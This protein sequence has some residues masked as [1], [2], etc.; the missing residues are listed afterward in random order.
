MKR[1]PMNRLTA[2]ALLLLMALGVNARAATG[3][4]NL[5]N[6]YFSLGGDNGMVTSLQ[7]DA[8]GAGSYGANTIA[9]GGHLAFVLGGTLMT[10]PSASWSLAG[11]SLLISGLPDST[12]LLI[13]LVGA[14]MT[15]QAQFSGAITVQHEWDLL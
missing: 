15:V 7:L 10:A 8:T 13:S 11:S 5:S 6:G 3:P 1:I 12:S 14:K 9:S 2:T 4:F